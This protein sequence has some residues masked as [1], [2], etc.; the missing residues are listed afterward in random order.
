ML[1]HFKGKTRMGRVCFARSIKNDQNIQVVGKYGCRY[2]LPNL[3][4]NLALDIFLNGIYEPETNEFLVN[5][6][7]KN[8]TV[9]DL[10]ANIGSV[11]IP[12]A[13]KRSDLRIICVEAS[14]HV[15]KYLQENLRQN[16]LESRVFCI[17]KAIS[18]KDDQSLPFYSDPG[19]FGKGSLS[20]VF[21]NKPIMVETITIDKLLFDLNIDSVGFIKADIEGYEYFAFAGGKQLLQRSDAPPVFF[22]FVDWA[23]QCANLVPGA[24]QKLLISYGYELFIYRKNR[25]SK[26]ASIM[27]KKSAMLY[28][29]KQ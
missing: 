23:E 29:R 2:L 6:I 4:E 16:D 24:T 22:E 5:A 15:F 27:D 26:L 9:L 17:N 1:P 10:G 21:T 25:M 8:A 12:L 18:D 11:T 13:I 20:P 3:C 28:A 19:N 14:P 7:P